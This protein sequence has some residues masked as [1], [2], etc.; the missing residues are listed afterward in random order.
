MFPEARILEIDL[1]NR[2][3]TQK[4]LDAETYRLYPGG[5][6]LALYLLFRHTPPDA[7]PLGPDNA[8][9]FAVSP[10]A[11][12]PVA[13]QSR[14]TV[15]ARSPL[16]GAIGDSQSGGYF[17]A[18]LKANGWDALVFIGQSA[19]PVYLHIDG[20]HCE[21]RSAGHL[22]G[23]VTGDAEAA[24]RAELGTDDLEI[25]QI[26]PAGEQRVRYANIINMC[27]RANGRTGM[28]AVMG[29]KQLK[30]VVI[31]KKNRGLQPVDKD[32]FKQLNTKVSDKIAANGSMESLQLYG[33][34]GELT[35][36]AEVGLLP[37]R[38]IST[39]YFPEE[40]ARAIGG[41]TMASTI[42]VKRE[43]C[44]GC[45]VYCK[46]VVEVP[47]SVDP[48]YGGP[49]YETAACFGSYCGINDLPAVARANMLCNMYGMDTISCGA[50]ISFA[51]ECFEKGLISADDTGG[52]DL[53][54]GNAAAMVQMVEQIA[55]RSTAFGRLLGEGSARAAQAIGPEAEQYVMAV[56]GH[57]MPAHMPQYKASLS[58]IYAANPFGAD[59]QSSEHDTSLSM[60]PDSTV[61]ERLDQLFP[62]RSQLPG[63]LDADKV[64]YAYYTQVFYSMLDSL[65]LCQFVWGP[66]WQL[67]GPK[68]V[69]LLL[70]AGIG[71]EAS[72]WE[73]MKIGER[74]LNLM[75][76]FNAKAGFTRAHD[77]LPRRFHEPLPEGPAAGAHVDKAA[78]DAAMDTYYRFAGWDPET[79]NPRPEKLEELGLGWIA[80]APAR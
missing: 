62:F 16:S 46:R 32:A 20:D 45:A 41:R 18:S 64:R 80:A 7:D 27:N 56:K 11:S 37:T 12:L 74:R 53:R 19:D 66:A 13:G 29:A 67:Y 58:V 50:T 48:L 78:W 35:D 61:R 9:V 63:E 4:T 2:T 6:A 36:H 21:L 54:F 42:L 49:E 65:G 79:G 28:G 38:N 51:M 34:D 8:L 1:T 72:M 10:L 44:F 33:T 17:P 30:A 24:L 70:K 59:H 47:G 77:K 5:S 14:M 68:D 60:P 76:A 57:E 3:C 22:W 25:A 73:L 55:T 15:A 31:R 40:D 43:T 26:G 39:G 23:K 52:A 69:I 75:R 71:W